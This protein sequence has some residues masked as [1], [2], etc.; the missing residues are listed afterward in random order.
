MDGPLAVGGRSITD[1]LV[2]TCYVGELLK[3]EI[4][5]SNRSIGDNLSCGKVVKK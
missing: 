2:T 5:G 4:L 3:G 1:Q